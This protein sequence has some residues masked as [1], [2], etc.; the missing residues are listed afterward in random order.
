MGEPISVGMDATV[1]EFPD[2]ERE[3]PAAPADLLGVCGDEVAEA[4]VVIHRL[5]GRRHSATVLERCRDAAIGAFAGAASI[6][7]SGTKETVVVEAT[8]RG[9]GSAEWAASAVHHAAE[10]VRQLGGGGYVPSGA[11]AEGNESREGGIQVR[12]GDP[13]GV[14]DRLASRAAPGQ[15]LLA[16]DGWSTRRHIR[17]LPA[18]GTSGAGRVA[19]WVLREVR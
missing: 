7:C 5:D 18:T 4:R 1:F 13:T 14:A 10:A 9:A 19:V 11:I 12:V 17:A 2:Q 15:I 6:R 3:V 8:F 16:G